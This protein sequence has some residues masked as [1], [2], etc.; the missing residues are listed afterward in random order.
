[1]RERGEGGGEGG[2]EGERRGR[3]INRQDHGAFGGDEMM[4]ISGRGTF[5]V[6][7]QEFASGRPTMMV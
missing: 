4:A 7:R 5:P 3:G 1:M 2:G 6:L